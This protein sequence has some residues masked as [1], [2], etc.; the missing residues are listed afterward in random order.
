MAIATGM[1]W[2]NVDLWAG[3][4]MI[5][6][7]CVPI[8]AVTSVVLYQQLNVETVAKRNERRRREEL[9]AYERM[10]TAL[11][12]SI[13]AGGAYAVDAARTMAKQVCR[14]VT[15]KSVF[16]RAAM[17]M[18]NAEGRLYCAGSAGVDDLTLNALLAWGEQVVAEERGATGAADPK[19]EVVPTRAIRPGSKSFT[20][21]IGTWENFD[22]EASKRKVEGKRERRKWRRAIISPLRTPG[23]RLVGAIAVCADDSARRSQEWM[24]SSNR[25]M[26]PGEERR[27]RGLEQAM[28]PIEALCAKLATTIEN[29]ALSERLLRAEKLAGL[30]QLAGG[31]AHALNNP[32]TAVLG[33]AEL[34]EET[35]TDPRVQQDARTIVSEARRMRDTVQSLLNFWRPVT[36]ADEP[37]QIGPIVRELTDACAATLEQ[38]G[39]KLIV[40]TPADAPPIRGSR[41]R[42]RQVLEHLLNNAAQAIAT[43]SEEQAREQTSRLGVLP[44]TVDEPEIEHSIRVTISHDERALHVIVSDTGPGFR[45]PGRVFDPFY[46]TRQPGEGAGLGLSICYGIVR[47]HGGEI[48]AFNLHPRG[49]AV[50]I[51]LPVRKTVTGES[52]SSDRVLVRDVA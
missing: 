48:S 22:P 1:G 21:P 36:S 2:D 50:V 5:A 44:S 46:T 31:V 43:R 34:I 10:D 20:I 38:R 49:A 9:E 11:P 30:G 32:L 7:I 25:G 23:G 40:T 13:G 17:L 24:K 45:E 39:V 8:L 14:I 6:M 41:E 18:R 15:E 37:V 52:G 35:S 42:L 19:S 51:E 12:A 47:E 27:E 4:H 29:A 3:A 16:P 28:G 26:K 33:F